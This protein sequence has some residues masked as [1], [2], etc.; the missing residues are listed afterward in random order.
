[1]ARSVVATVVAIAWIATHHHAVREGTWGRLPDLDDARVAT[2]R[3]ARAGPR[4][5][6][7]HLSPRAS[8][9][10]RPRGSIPS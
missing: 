5:L 2:R 3:S 4:T 9:W 6:A 10:R 8:H 7:P 1:V